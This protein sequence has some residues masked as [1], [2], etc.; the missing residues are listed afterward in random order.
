MAK[1][2]LKFEQ[3]ESL[4]E[5][6]VIIY[7]GKYYTTLSK[8]AFLR[9][10]TEKLNYLSDKLETALNEIDKLKKQLAIDHGEVE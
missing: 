6:D 9:T 5:N 10:V 2:I 7:N 8:D 3:S 1:I 4:K